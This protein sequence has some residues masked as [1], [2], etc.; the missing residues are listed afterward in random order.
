MPTTL[1]LGSLGEDI[2][3]TYLTDS[4]LRV[5]DRNWRC[6]EGELDIGAR[7]CDALVFC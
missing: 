2:A 4:G 1:E 7:E 3:A 6:R 5:L